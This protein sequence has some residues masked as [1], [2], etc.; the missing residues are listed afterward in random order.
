[1]V[2]INKT[3]GGTIDI[4]EPNDNKSETPKT[5]TENS[6]NKNDILW[7]TKFI[8]ATIPGTCNAY[9]TEFIKL[10]QK[11]ATKLMNTIATNV[12]I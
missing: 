1:M 8:T 10:K 7:P 2:T 11:L 6:T 12:S 5:L 4:I 9:N 3:E